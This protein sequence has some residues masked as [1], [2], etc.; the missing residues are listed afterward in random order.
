MIPILPIIITIVRHNV[1]M[2]LT[3]YLTLNSIKCTVA[4]IRILYKEIMKILNEQ[5]FDLPK[6]ILQS[7]NTIYY[8]RTIKEQLSQHDLL[9]F[10]LFEILPMFWYL[11][12]P[13]Y[14]N[15]AFIAADTNN[16]VIS[17]QSFWIMLKF[18]PYIQLDV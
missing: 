2:K 14:C 12:C 17:T 9:G 1:F 3:I 6:L 18:L 8:H 16:V 11:V 15:E 5:R 7:K 10:F 4:S 13:K